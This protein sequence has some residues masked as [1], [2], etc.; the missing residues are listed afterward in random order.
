MK[1]KTSYLILIVVGMIYNLLTAF[2]FKLCGS[3]FLAEIF[4][5]I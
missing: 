5:S 3:G 4:G 2:G 1:T